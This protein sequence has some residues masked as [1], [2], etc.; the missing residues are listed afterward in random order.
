MSVNLNLTLEQMDV[1]YAMAKEKNDPA[2]LELVGRITEVKTAEKN[3]GLRAAA[4]GAVE[5]QAIDVA[6]AANLNDLVI[7]PEIVKEI[8][9]LFIL[10]Q[11]GHFVPGTMSIGY[12]SEVNIPQTTLA[13]IALAETH[14]PPKA[15]ENV[16]NFLA[17]AIGE[18]SYTSGVKMAGF[19]NNSV[20]RL[21]DFHSE[22]TGRDISPDTDLPPNEKASVLYQWR[23]DMHK[24]TT[25]ANG[26]D[27]GVETT[28]K[29][30]WNKPYVIFGKAP[31][32]RK[33]TGGT[34][35]RRGR[36]PAPE[37]YK[38][39]KD[40]GIHMGANEPESVAG[41]IF[42]NAVEKYDLDT[43]GTSW[44]YASL[45]KS[46]NEPTYMALYNAVEPVAA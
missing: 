28:T 9:L 30:G 6:N 44:S 20:V 40:W 38:S 26:N 17:S 3:K 31:A 36:T 14:K 24:T 5:K 27:E 16:Q 4:K 29:P 10:G 39:W 21:N 43:H 35:T 2:S 25:Q 33:S 1:L 32:A 11:E 34:G 19:I 45:L 37:G 41:K 23:F 18:E 7:D 42:N 12:H 46:G 13:L 22:Q 15:A 8:K